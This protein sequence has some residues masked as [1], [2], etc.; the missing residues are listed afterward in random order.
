[1]NSNYIFNI[2]PYS[3]Y[4]KNGSDLKK[5]KNGSSSLSGI[6]VLKITS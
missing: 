1:L 2:Q 3:P 6:S 5:N 4:E